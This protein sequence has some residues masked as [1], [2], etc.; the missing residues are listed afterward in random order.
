MQKPN[1]VEKFLKQ[2]NYHESWHDD[3]TQ[4]LQQ[5]D[6]SYLNALLGNQQWLPGSYNIFNALSLPKNKVTYLLIGESPYPRVQSA[7]GYAFW[8][9][10]VGSLWSETGLSKEVN[11]ATSLRNFIKMLLVADKKL[12]ADKTTQPDIAKLNKSQLIETNSELFE[13]LIQH[14][15][16]LLNASPVLSELA[17]RKEAKQWQPFLCALLNKLSQTRPDVTLILFGKIAKDFN[18]LG[19]LSTH[20]RLCAEHPY[21]ISFIT[22]QRVTDFFQAF[23]LLHRT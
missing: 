6:A 3:L 15:F 5:M 23:K 17:V 14:G 20:K 18:K 7:N 1:V 9:Q 11:R 12:S 19:L 2:A 4:A 21:N 22:N 8:D 10:A 13:K 16:L